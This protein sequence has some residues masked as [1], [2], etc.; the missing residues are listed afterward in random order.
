MPSGATLFKSLG[1]AELFL[2][3]FSDATYFMAKPPT[4]LPHFNIAP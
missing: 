3:Y 1:I 4:V 2:A